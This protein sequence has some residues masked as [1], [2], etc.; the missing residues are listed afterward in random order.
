MYFS[1]HKLEV[2][3]HEKGQKERDGHK[4]Q[5]RENT[6]NKHLGFKFVRINLDEKDYD[7]F[8]EISKIHDHIETSSKK[9][10][11]D[12]ISKAKLEFEFKSNHLIKSRGLKYVICKIFPSL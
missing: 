4:E 12:K 11:I 8:T 10:L 6:I 1:Q 3:N 5:E 2:E 9:S 7:I